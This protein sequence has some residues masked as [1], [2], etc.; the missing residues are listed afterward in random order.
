MVKEKMC[1]TIWS[2]NDLDFEAWKKDHG[3]EYPPYLSEHVL[4]GIMY[5]NNNS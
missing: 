3:A 2:N 4:M 5:E 1:H